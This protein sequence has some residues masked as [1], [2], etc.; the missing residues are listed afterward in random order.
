MEWDRQPREGA[1]AYEAFALYREMGYT[2]SVS[3]VAQRLGKQVSLIRR[4]SSAYDW[5]SRVKAWDAHQ[6]QETRQQQAQAVREMR[7]RHAQEALAIQEKALSRLRQM[8][9]GELSASDVI[10]FFVEG[11]RLERVARGE[12]EAINET[13]LTGRE[14]SPVEVNISARE[15]LRSRIA[16]LSAREKSQEVTEA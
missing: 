14:D 6:E 2:R 1:R 7:K 5:V 12:P 13:V 3:K 11:A 15:I 10:K 4:W 16:A 8:D 9:I